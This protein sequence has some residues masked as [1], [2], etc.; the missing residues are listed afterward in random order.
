MFSDDNQSISFLKEGGDQ[1]FE[2]AMKG[3]QDFSSKV[4]EKTDSHPVDY[5]AQNVIRNLDNYY[6]K[7]MDFENNEMIN[8]PKE[9]MGKLDNLYDKIMESKKDKGMEVVRNREFLGDPKEPPIK[10]RPNSKASSCRQSLA[11]DPF[12]PSGKYSKDKGH[13]SNLELQRMKTLPEQESFDESLYEYPVMSTP[14]IKG[15]FAAGYEPKPQIYYGQSNQGIN[16]FGA[17]VQGVPVYSPAYQA[18][19]AFNQ[20][21]RNA[22]YQTT[23]Q[24]NPGNLPFNYQPHNQQPKANFFSPNLGYYNNNFWMLEPNN[25]EF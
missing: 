3:L 21:Y 22:P 8:P 5:E 1:E 20:N 4:I 25:L 14:S 10:S 19:N 6:D 2:N 13:C 9:I 17:F 23:T 11:S 16:P 18:S 15:S 12:V 24:I 7:K